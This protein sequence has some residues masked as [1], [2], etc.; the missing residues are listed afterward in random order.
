[1]MTYADISRPLTAQDLSAPSAESETVAPVLKHL[2]D[3]HRRL[4]RM[5]AEGL[6]EQ[7]AGIACGLTESRVSILKADPTFRNLISFYRRQVEATF[8]STAE[9]LAELTNLAADEVITRLEEDADKFDLEDLIS[10]VKMGADR[11]GHAPVS[12][13]AA[14]NVTFNIGA[15]LDAAAA[16][17]KIIEGKVIN[18]Q[19]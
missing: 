19:D 16:R 17:A 2:S 12:K 8:Q 6:S 7:D 14:P 13:T 5:L 1:M 10:I 15:R 3:R 9:R 18:E 11:T 4:A